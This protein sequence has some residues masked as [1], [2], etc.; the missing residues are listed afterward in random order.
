MVRAPVDRRLRAGRPAAAHRDRT[1]GHPRRLIGSG[2]AADAGC[3]AGVRQRVAG[4]CGRGGYR[5]GIA[6]RPASP[7]RCISTALAARCHP[8]RRRRCARPV[9]VV[10]RGDR[11]VAGGALVDDARPVRHHRLAVRSTQPHD[12]VDPLRAQR[13][14]GHHRNGGGFQRPRRV[15]DLQF[16]HGVRRGHPGAA[17]PGGR[18]LPA[19]GSG[20]GR[21]DDHRRGVG[22]GPRPAVR[23]TADVGAARAGETGHRLGAGRSRDGTARTRRQRC[24]GQLRSG[25]HRTADLRTRSFPVVPGRR[26]CHRGHGRRSDQAPAPTAATPAKLAKIVQRSEA[27][28]I[29][30][31]LQACG[32]NR[33]ETARRLGISERTLRYRLASFREA[34]LAVGGGRR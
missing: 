22:G 10:G 27:H 23:T 33:I 14:C 25:R 13:D 34:G 28:A 30:E 6:G 19:P 11:A 5:D 8:C 20:V 16:V 31:T 1:G 17:D 18:T 29:M 24:A 4:A 3:V 32:G 7:G 26:W 15:R 9:R 2:A 12:P 21:A